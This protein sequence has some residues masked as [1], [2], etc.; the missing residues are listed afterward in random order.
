MLPF[1]KNSSAVNS[2]ICCVAG[3]EGEYIATSNGVIVMGMCL[4]LAYCLSRQYFIERR[5]KDELLE[6]RV[7]GHRR[8]SGARSVSSAVSTASPFMD[9]YPE[10]DSRLEASLLEGTST[11]N[12]HLLFGEMT[13]ATEDG[14]EKPAAPLMITNPAFELKTGLFCL[15]MLARCSFVIYGLLAYW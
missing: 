6:K 11:H 9:N 13:D 12:A 15:L 3:A 1:N 5:N 4:V 8:H 14:S 2:I 10:E 7:I